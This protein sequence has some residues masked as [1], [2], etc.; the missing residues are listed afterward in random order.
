MAQAGCLY[1]D[2]MASTPPDPRVLD[3][4]DETLRNNSANPHARQHAPGAAAHRAVATA[5]KQVAGLI[6]AQ[7]DEV[8]FA[9]GATEANNT[10][11]TGIAAH[12][13][14]IGKTHIITSKAEHKSV[15][16]PLEA[17]A[18]EGFTVE[19]L[20]V[21]PCAMVDTPMLEKALRD[22][23]GLVSL[24]AVNNETGTLNP[25]VE[26]VDLLK[27]RGVITHCDIAQAA[28]KMPLDV[29][30]LG[31]DMASLS[32]HKM[33]APQ[34]IG[35]LY[36]RRELQD[37]L[38]PLIRGGGQQNGL[39]GGTVPV[40][41]CA[42]LGAA[43]EIAGAEMT[44][45]I[46]RLQRQ[47]ERLMNQLRMVWPEITVNSHSEEDWRVPGCINLRFDGV[48]NEWLITATPG[49]AFSTGSAC[50]NTG[51]AHSHV[52]MA[53]TGDAQAARESLRISFGRF[54]TDEDIDTA[55]AQITAALAD[56]AEM[57]NQ[58]REKT[59]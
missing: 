18:A 6:N 32:G 22:D 52:I 38:T 10:A 28:G 54:T 41:L 13:K 17:L 40:A 4:L 11:L 33:Y 27:D 14:S 45:E 35:A 44:E 31:I 30:A 25:W 5:R 37:K 51:T 9:S 34:G 36:V 26:Y 46:P 23:T 3:V 19:K 55:A 53:M 24:M 48:E 58:N 20:D 57:T 39:R 15:L 12:L 2:Y 49:L 29:R 42:A 47:R 8:I 1:L 59:A 50:A 7:A 43:C 21:L 56:I 16:E